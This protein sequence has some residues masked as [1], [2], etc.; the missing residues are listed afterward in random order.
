MHNLLTRLFAALICCALLCP[1][2]AIAEEEI[3]AIDAEPALDVEFV[4]EDALEDD[5][6]VL[7]TGLAL[8][9]GPDETVEAEDD[10]LIDVEEAPAGEDEISEADE[11]APETA[12]GAHAYDDILLKRTSVTI[13]VGEVY[14]DI[15]ASNCD[16]PAT[17]SDLKY[18]SSNSKVVKVV[19]RGKLKGLKTGKA[20]ITIKNKWDTV[21]LKVV[22]KKRPSKVTISPATKTLYLKASIALKAKLP[23]GTASFKK[24]WTSSNT[25]VATVSKSGRV[26]AKKAGTATITVKTYNGKKSKCKVTVKNVRQRALLIGQNAYPGNELRGCINDATTMSGILKNA[27]NHFDTKV[28]KNAGAQEIL[29]AIY[30]YLVPGSKDSDIS[31]FYYS[32]HGLYADGDTDYQGSLCGVDDYY[33]PP[34]LLAD[35]LMD[36]KGRV[37][38]IIDACHSGALIGTK[39]AKGSASG[40]AQQFMKAFT[41][42][43]ESSKAGEFR[44]KD[45][46]FVLVAAGFSESSYD[47]YFDGSGYPQGAFTA[48]LVKGV[49]ASY[50]SGKFKSGI[51]ADTS[52]DKR[53]SF[54]EAYKY[55]KKIV[56][57][58]I[59]YEDP[60]TVMM[61]G[62]DTVC[63]FSRV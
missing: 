20:T 3:P 53:V 10:M 62:T 30:D 48:A 21:K 14:T 2:L 46:F 4:E 35:C 1:G 52:G 25:S 7:D 56:N 60:Q 13:G 51:P 27:S 40:F 32:G 16:V 29:D 18:S 37:Y 9:I 6:S 22:V 50:P 17:S 19:S 57:K 24:T 45:K 5:L 36:V 28:I 8:E 34:W 12:L 26:T 41:N 61:Y 63:L 55:S 39:G 58:W 42:R 49:G 11:E 33:F 54:G 44:V 38:V 23:S 59:G 31:L 15:M 47:G 43:L